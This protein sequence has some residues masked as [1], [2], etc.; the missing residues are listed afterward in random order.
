[1]SVELELAA[2]VLLDVDMESG[3][4]K[5]FGWN[6]VAYFCELTERHMTR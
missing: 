6:T 5:L 1:V 2:P 3:W 4:L